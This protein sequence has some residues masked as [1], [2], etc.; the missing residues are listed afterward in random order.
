MGMRRK[1]DESINLHLGQVAFPQDFSAEDLT[2]DPTYYDDT[3]TIDPEYSDAEV[4]PETGDNYSSTEL[5]LPIR[6]VC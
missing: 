2:P 6:V 3:D 1:F 5:M 4:T